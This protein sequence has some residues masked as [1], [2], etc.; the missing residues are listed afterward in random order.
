MTQFVAAPVGSVYS[1]EAQITGSDSTAGIQFEIIPRKLV[2][3][4]D[5]GKEFEAKY[6]R[7]EW[8]S[9]TMKIYIMTSTGKTF[10]IFCS[11]DS[12]TVEIM[13]KVYDTEGILPNQQRLIFK[14]TLLEDGTSLTCMI[15]TYP[16]R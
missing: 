16:N 3:V 6:P 1:V 4:I 12:G 11:P 14:G 7:G 5:H 8:P 15:S 9:S 13:L 10:T 2:L